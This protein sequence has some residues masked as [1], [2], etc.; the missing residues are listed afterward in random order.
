[1]NLRGDPERRIH[2][3]ETGILVRAQWPNG[4]WDS[5]DIAHL[6]PQSLANWLRS[7]GGSNPW[8]ESVVGLLLGH[9]KLPSPE[10]SNEQADVDARL[11]FLGELGWCHYCGFVKDGPCYC[12]ADD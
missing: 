1:M 6:E 10:L 9:E 7:R 2:N 3:P 4:T 12:L 11:R 8:A 5:I